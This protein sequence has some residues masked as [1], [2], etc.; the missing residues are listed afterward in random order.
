MFRG[1]KVGWCTTLVTQGHCALRHT[2]PLRIVFCIVTRTA[3]LES[4]GSGACRSACHGIIYAIVS[5]E[6]L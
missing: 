5:Y 1:N 6:Q 2:R 3:R 4:A